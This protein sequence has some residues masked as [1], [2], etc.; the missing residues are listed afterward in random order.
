MYYF[1]IKKNNFFFP[2]SK[3][4]KIRCVFFHQEHISVRSNHIPNAQEPHGASGHLPGQRRS[5]S[6]RSLVL[7][8]LTRVPSFIPK[9]GG[10]GK[11]PTTDKSTQLGRRR[12]LWAQP[13]LSSLTTPLRW[14]SLTG[15]SR[16]RQLTGPRFSRVGSRH[17]R[18]GSLRIHHGQETVRR[19]SWMCVRRQKIKIKK[20]G[21]H[22]K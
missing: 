4:L 18:P 2:H 15:N 5:S 19:A 1:S 10:R 12:N 6:S 20:G 16:S 3:C 21:I 14:P 17:L 22:P 7:K 11:H 13:S 9:H 8:Y